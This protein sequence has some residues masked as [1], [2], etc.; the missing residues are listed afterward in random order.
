MFGKTENTTQ[1]GES[2]EEIVT[3][4]PEQTALVGAALAG[5]VRGGDMMLLLGPLGAGKTVFVRGLARGLGAQSW[6]GSPTYTIVTEYGTQPP[7]YHVDLYR[8]V[9]EEAADLGLE[10]YARD[11]SVVV[12]EWAERA[13]EYLRAIARR[14]PMLVE[15]EPLDAQAR[16]IRVRRPVWG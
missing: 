13:Q 7:L 9:T 10:E 8:L 14:T 3:S 12:V 4:S 5:E 6:Q 16:C 15:I 2:S 1:S 11:D